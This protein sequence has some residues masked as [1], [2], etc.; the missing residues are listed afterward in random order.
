MGRRNT[1]SDHNPALPPLHPKKGA[2]Q[3]YKIKY[4]RKYGRD[5]QQAVPI[6]FAE[7]K[8]GGK[9]KLEAAIQI[10]EV[11]VFED[12]GT[13]HKF[14]KWRTLIAGTESGALLRPG[15]LQERFSGRI[16][17]VVASRSATVA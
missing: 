3:E 8:A 10:G 17:C 4:R 5:E 6:T 11:A 12:P 1:P 13:G 15:A 14:Y 16:W 7:K 9:D 2:I